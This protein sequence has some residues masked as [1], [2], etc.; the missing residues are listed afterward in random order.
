MGRAVLCVQLPIH[1]TLWDPTQI[2]HQIGVTQTIHSAFLDHHGVLGKI[3]IPILTTA[4]IAPSNPQPPRIPM[5]QYPI[6]EHTL[7]EWKSRVTVDSYAAITLARATALSL[8]DSLEFPTGAI[9]PKGTREISQDTTTHLFDL[10]NTLQVIIGETMDT[11]TAM[12]PHKS[13]PPPSRD[14]FPR[15]LSPIQCDTI[16][17]KYVV[18][19][20]PSANLFA[21][22]PRRIR[23]HRTNRPIRIPT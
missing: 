17:L 1:L 23:P 7:E 5:F 19:R 22:P 3:T 10:A 14:T 6:P 13:A 2:T 11:A 16:S 4:A 9:S 20:R 12:F 8:N 15:H 18:E 21:L